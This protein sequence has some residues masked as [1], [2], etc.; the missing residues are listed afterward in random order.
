MIQTPNNPNS[1]NVGTRPAVRLAFRIEGEYWNCYMA[2][3][4]TMEGAHLL[5]SIL[6]AIVENNAGHKHAFKKLMESVLSDAVKRATGRRPTR[7]DTNPAPEHERTK[8]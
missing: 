1:P 3:P 8:E 7:M 5:G 2:Q 4:Q 6:A